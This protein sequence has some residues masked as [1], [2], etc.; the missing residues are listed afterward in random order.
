MLRAEEA[1]SIALRFAFWF[2]LFPYIL[3]SGRGRPR[4]DRF[5]MGLLGSLALVIVEGQV[6]SALGLWEP[7]SVWGTVLA[8]I[9]ATIAR[10]LRGVNWESKL[11]KSLERTEEGGVEELRNLVAK[12]R[13]SVSSRRQRR[14][15]ARRGARADRDVLAWVVGAVVMAGA[16]FL[17]YNQVIRHYYLP[18]SESYQ[19]LAWVKYLQKSPATVGQPTHIYQE[20]VYPYGY[21]A[22]IS[23]LSLLDFLD[24]FIVISFAGPLTGLLLLLSVGYAAYRLT[25]RVISAALAMGVLA[26]GYFG[27]GVTG[28]SRAISPL[29]PEFGA[30]F[31]LPSLVS[32]WLFLSTR[33][34]DQAILAVGAAFLTAAVSPWAFCYL[35]VALLILGVVASAA[36]LAAGRTAVRLFLGAAGAGIVTAVPLVAARL[37]GIPFHPG[38]SP[39]SPGK[40]ILAAG[41]GSTAGG[42]ISA[43]FAHVGLGAGVLLLVAGVIGWRR[44]EKANSP[45]AVGLGTMI[46]LS[47]VLSG[48]WEGPLFVDP[49]LASLLFALFA[50]LG[51]GLGLNFVADV[52]MLNGRWRTGIAA[53]LLIGAVFYWKPVPAVPLGQ[54]EYDDEAKA[55]LYIVHMARRWDWTIISTQAALPKVLGYGFHMQI[56]EFA[57]SYSY[58]QIRE[59]G[60]EL[61]T[62]DTGDFFIFI[63]KVPLGTKETIEPNAQTPFPVGRGLGATTDGYYLDPQARASIM[64]R[65]WGFVEEYRKIHP[66]LV[67]VIVDNQTF[68]VYRITHA[69]GP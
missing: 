43:G 48:A 49:A 20:G 46:V 60:F 4:L 53:V 18:A 47:F 39:W 58:D 23:A 27:S 35:L 1:L 50:A 19:H 31:A 63:E 44:G 67:K 10:R 68:R 7:I 34:R 12:G 21:H 28:A 25:G 41:G 62:K 42:W 29:P 15:S 22:F 13:E 64:A 51:A 65:S 2:G 54:Y 24:P 6:L 66:D 16:L 45:L 69:G 37:Y 11:L 52:L 32:A 5:M 26:A 14:P 36:R 59:P 57:R 9:L 61:A 40:G 30:V 17:L 38:L 33:S 55:Y 56:L 8:F 3:L